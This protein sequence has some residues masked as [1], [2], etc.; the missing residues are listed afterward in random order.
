MTQPTPGFQPGNDA[1]AQA[2]AAKAY[3]KAIRPWYK[4]KR[5]VIPLAV[6]ALAIVSSALS[7]GDDSPTA[8]DTPA[9]DAPAAAPEDQTP[10]ATTPK[11]KKVE[12]KVAK[13]VATVKVSAKD[14]LAAYEDNE[15]AADQRFKG[16][17]LQVSGVMSK[18]DTDVWHDDK[19]ILRIGS[20]AQ[21]EVW[22]VNCSDIPQSKLVNLSE[23]ENVTVIGEFDDGGDLG[24]DLKKC[25]IV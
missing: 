2:K 20:G 23:G 14:L 4:K 16:K 6:V 18:V 1:K 12:K 22:T 13:K 21:F 19:Y 17:T 11:K 15:L 25:S 10:A 7:S 5:F 9:A 24:V 8:S 3:A